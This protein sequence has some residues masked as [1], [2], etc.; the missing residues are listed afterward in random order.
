VLPGQ[1]GECVGVGVTIGQCGKYKASARSPVPGLFYVGFDAGSN[2][3]LM[4][5][6]QAVDSGLNVAP[7]V[8][9]YHLEKKQAAFG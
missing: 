8:Y 2:K 3:G 1:G 7:M 4:A 5:T 9:H 6:H